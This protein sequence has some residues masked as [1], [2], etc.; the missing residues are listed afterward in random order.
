M[1][2]VKTVAELL[3][4]DVSDD[5]RAAIMAANITPFIP[6]LIISEIYDAICRCSYGVMTCVD[7]GRFCCMLMFLFLIEMVVMMVI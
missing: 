1:S 4:T 3:N 6:K 7:R 5:I 2:M